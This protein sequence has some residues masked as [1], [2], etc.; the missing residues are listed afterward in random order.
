[1]RHMLLCSVSIL[2]SA[3]GGAAMAQPATRA[4]ASPSPQTPTPGARPAT[5]GQTIRGTIGPDDPKLTADR[6]SYEVYRVRVPAGQ[7]LVATLTSTAFQPVLGLGLKTDDDCENCTI[8]VG[9]TDKP[10]TGAFNV[11]AGGFVEVRVNTMNEGESGDFTL[12]LTSVTP[13]PLSAQPIVFG[14]SKTGALTANDATT[15]NDNV[16]T[17]AYALRLAVGQ[18]VQ[19]DMS[20]SEFDPKLELYS[21]GESVAQDDDGGPGTSARIRFTAP[22]AGVYQ[23]RAMSLTS[24]GLGAYTLRAGARPAVVPMPA[25]RPLVLGTSVPGAI[26]AT[27]PSYEND[28]E[29]TRAVR[30]SFNATAGNVYKITATKKGETELD[31]RVSVGKLRN[32][33]LEDPASDDDGGGELNAALRFRPATSGIYVLEVSGVSEGFGAYDVKVVQA[34]PDRAAGNPVA[35]TLGTEYKGSL[36]DGG[37]RRSDDTLF[38]GYSIALK[39]GQRV[40]FDLKK[41]GE[42]TL[43]PKL[44]IGKGTVA[45][46]EQIVEDDDGGADL[47]A[48][49]RFVAPADGTYIVRATTVAVNNE[50]AFTLSA[51]AT[52]PPILPPAPTAIQS[53]QVLRGTLA[54]TDPTLNDQTYYDRYVLTG[55]VGDTFEI[56]VNAEPFDVIV[57]ARSAL[58]EDDDYTTDDDGGGGTNAKLTYTIT[59]AGPQTIRVTSLGE[60]AVGDYTISVI[61][62]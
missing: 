54:A 42:S 31:P 16:A 34:P 61:K 39:A 60:E 29:E 21:G 3:L 27:T 12:A 36:T 6:S 30:Y 28:G 4:V 7:R 25:P 48:R 24:G 11:P 58:R 20:S 47:N 9:E 45:A 40:T 57:G 10:A 19:I 32:G 51:A 2:A 5:L 37:P 33:V 53:G 43:D 50:G 18:Q 38:A 26:T 62:K 46:F 59:T 13:T 52:P 35:M 49:I 56:S 8:S 14:Q 15:G 23:I 22:R 44:E 55:Q 1:M 41:E 17:D